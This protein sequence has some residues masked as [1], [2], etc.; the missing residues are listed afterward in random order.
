MVVG[1]ANV[2]HTRLDP[3]RLETFEGLRQGG[4]T[5]AELIRRAIDALA[6]REGKT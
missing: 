5:D 6:E 3:V 4:E 1:N 2:K